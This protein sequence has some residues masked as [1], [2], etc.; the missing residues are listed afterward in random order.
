MPVRGN[1][2]RRIVRRTTHAQCMHISCTCLDPKGSSLTRNRGF[3]GGLQPY[4]VRLT[5]VSAAV[6]EPASARQPGQEPGQIG[7]PV[8][9]GLPEDRP[10]MGAR[11]GV[12]TPRA[13]AADGRPWP[14]RR[15][16]A[17]AVL[18]SGEAEGQVQQVWRAGA[19]RE[20]STMTTSTAPSPPTSAGSAGRGEEGWPGEARRRSRRGGGPERGLPGARSSSSST[21]RPSC[22]APLSPGVFF[23]CAGPVGTCPQAR[24]R[25]EG[26]ADR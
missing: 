22:A 16:S 20:E 8:G 26:M 3:W 14:E 23:C 25:R 13:A 18:A 5:R 4:S 7:L 24:P 21:V 6:V 10:E 17:R 2:L 15:L 9:A 1:G 11:R 19:A 12:R